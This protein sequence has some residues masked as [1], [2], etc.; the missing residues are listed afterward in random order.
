MNNSLNYE[1]EYTDIWHNHQNKLLEEMEEEDYHA[2][3][4][5]IQLRVPVVNKV[6]Q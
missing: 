3:L 4:D 1:D 6:D 5:P 2:D